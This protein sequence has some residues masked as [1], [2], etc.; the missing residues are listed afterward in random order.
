MNTK[1]NTP[2]PES[3]R[4]ALSALFDGELVGDVARFALKRLDH[5]QAWRDTCG[6]WQHIGDALRAKA[7]ALPSS[8]PE[9]V[10][11]ALRDEV[12]VAA[13]PAQRAA[14]GGRIRWGSVGMAASAAVVAFFLARMPLGSDAGRD[15]A[16]AQVAAQA[17]QH[18]PVQ[19][20]AAPDQA[21]QQ[22]SAAAA[23]VAGA[24][25]LSE[26]VTQ[27][28]RNVA[29]GR[30]ATD[31]V[32]ST[33]VAA[34]SS[35]V[36]GEAPQ[37]MPINANLVADAPVAPAASALQADTA[38]PWPRAVLPQLNGGGTLSADYATTGPSFYPFKPGPT[39]EPAANDD[40]APASPPEP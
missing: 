28:S 27:R 30:A 13:V 29:R 18:A 38:R 20:P 32:V 11:D 23:M 37:P 24:R 3:D 33:A 10:R 12:A 5:D 8:F 21:L 40:T 2:H 14:G 36:T 22:A 4:E 7:D 25:P 1:T 15:A 17:A 31:R 16:P 34:K 19:S 35:P 39:L 6:R 9:R 26:R